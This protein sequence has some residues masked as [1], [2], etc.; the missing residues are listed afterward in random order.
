M[1]HAGT[2]VAGKSPDMHFI[3]DTVLE[4][5]YS[6]FLFRD[7]PVK[8]VMDHSGLIEGVACKLFPPFA[9][10][11]NCLGI[12]VQKIFF[13]V[14]KQPFGRVP[15]T[16]DGI[17]IFKF[18]SFRPKTNIEY[19]FLPGNPAERESWRREPGPF[20]GIKEVHRKYRNR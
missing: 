13:S 1:F 9:L 5:G 10:A 6:R 19:T 15:G 14:K 3:D 20:C 4:T 12:G 7:F 2:F 11:G 16:V 17:G 8:V 18:I